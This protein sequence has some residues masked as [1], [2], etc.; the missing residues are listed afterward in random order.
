MNHRRPTAKALTLLGLLLGLPAVGCQD[1]LSP[2]P[3]PLPSEAEEATLHDFLGSEVRNPSAF[4]VLT[5]GAVRTDQTSGWDY[6]YAAPTDRG[7]EFRPRSMVVGDSSASGLQRV[8]QTFEGLTEAPE[9]GYVTDDRV[10]VDSGAVYAG[11]SRQ[12]PQRFGRC[13]HFLKLE[14][15]EVDRTAGT[16]RFRHLSNPNCNERVLIPDTT[17]ENGGDGS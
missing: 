7:P 12:N 4:D 5:S 16:V 10:A 6:I 3:R 9:G 14:V 17:Q 8:D 1:N 15:L 13:R 11:R 2:E